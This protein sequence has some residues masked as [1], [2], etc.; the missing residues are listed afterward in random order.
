MIKNFF[1]FGNNFKPNCKNK[2]T[3]ENTLFP[4]SQICL[5]LTLHPILL[6][7]FSCSLYVWCVHMFFPEPFEGKLHV[8]WPFILKYSSVRFLRIGIYFYITSLRLSTL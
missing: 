7:L 8:S 5:S 4:F 3:M 1:L 6:H 2:N